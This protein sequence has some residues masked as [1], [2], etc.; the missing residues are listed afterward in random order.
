M[1]GLA[2]LRPATRY[3]SR[4]A[5]DAPESVASGSAFVHRQGPGRQAVPGSEQAEPAPRRLQTR[6]PLDI[7][8]QAG[9]ARKRPSIESA[10][11]TKAP[12]PS[13]SRSG[14]VATTG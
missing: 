11:T 5:G 3:L 7:S 13:G 10:A 9:L 6:Q 8:R 12:S 1:T 2:A 4:T 14:E